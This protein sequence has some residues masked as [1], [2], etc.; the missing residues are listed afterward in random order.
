MTLVRI[1]AWR[2]VADRPLRSCLTAAGVAVGVAF[3]FS[4]LSLNAQ[5]ASTVSDTETLLAGPRLLQVTPAAPGGL[6]EDLATKLAADPRVEAAAPLLVTRSKASNGDHETGV[7]VLAGTPDVANLVPTE[8]IPSMDQVQLAKDGGDIVLSRAL[9]QRLHAEPGDEVTIHASTGKTPLR[10]AAI[11]S[12]PALDRINGGMVAAMPLAPAQEVFGR[13]GRVDQIMLLAG[14]DA[15]VDALRRD[16]GNAIDGIGVVSSPGAAAS[17]STDFLGIQMVTSMVGAIVVLAALVLVFHTMSMAT[18]ER[19][20]EIALARSLGSTRRQLLIVTLIEAGLL[21]SAGTAVGLLAGG[22]LARVVVPLARV[23]YGG[24]APVDLPTGVSFQVLPAVVAAAAGIGGAVLGAVLPAR[25]AARAAPVDA[26]RPAAPYEWR[27][28]GRPTRRLAIAAV[29]AAL[30]AAGLALLDRPVSGKL[31]DPVAAL[32]GVA[33]FAGTLILVTMLVP[34]ATRAAANLLGRLSPTT[35]RLA[36]DAVRSNPRR[37]TINVMALLLPV[38]IM[39]TTT[40][41]F[42][43]GLDQ[44]GRFARATVAAPLNVDA[45]SYIGGPASP[46]ASQPLAHAHQSVLEAVPGVRAVLPYE[47]A[48]IRLPDDTQ[49]VVYAVPLAAAE[50]AGVADMVQVARLASDPDE[51]TRRLVAGEI[52]AS[53]FAA[54]A[55]DLHIGDHLTL[56]T[57]TGPETFTVGGF[58]DDWAFQG[59]FYVD[60]DTYRAV[61]G[62]AGAHRFAIV[63]AAGTSPDDLKG[64]IEAALAAAAIPAHVITRDEAIADLQTNTTILLPLLRGMTLASLVFAVLALANAAFTAVTERRWLFALQQTLGMTR[65]EIAR[66]LALEA[67]VVG[68]VGTIGAVL[69]GIWYAT[70]NNRFLGNM[71]AITIGISVPWT[72]VAT[73]AVLGI[74]VALGATYFPRRT[75]KRMTI[76]ESLRFD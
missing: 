73:A 2:R 38:T 29:G 71:L 68:V 7:F 5:L 45:D 56:P 33:V 17:A 31:N 1:L 12:S 57:P 13:T 6:P 34:F 41:A 28:P 25:S 23:A 53:H 59:T 67:I 16:L 61:W 21:G 15:D 9:A 50:R 44:I 11:V 37:T 51:F 19:R 26:L 30:L 54:R 52:A 35:G 20:T 63:P 27:D 32:P 47:N 65:R 40:V 66:S 10:V 43:G 39:I 14:P 42:D 18:A 36:G 62:D 49:G 74:A 70:V 76:I 46:V 58:F 3:L 48:H 8:A 60:L 22:A 55:L 69:F 72:F 64:R 75:A 4:I 24:S